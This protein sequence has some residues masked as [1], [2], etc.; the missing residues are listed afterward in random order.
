MK[1]VVYLDNNATTCVAPE[2]LA[3]MLPYFSEWYGNPS[4]MHHFGGQVAKKLEE[5]RERVAALLGAEPTEIVF[6]GCGTESDSTAIRGILESYPEK[7]H[8]VTTRVEHPAVLTLGRYLAKRGYEVTELSVD[9]Q[10]MIDL[11]EL[12]DVVSDHTAIVSLM[13]ANNETGTIFPVEEAA[14][15]AKSVDAVFHTDA[16][17]AAGKI[18]INMA[19]SNMDLLAISGHKLHA[20]KGVGVLYVRRGTR[21][22]PF[23]LGGHQE[24]GRRAG[25][26]NTAS[27]VAL[28]KACGI[29]HDQDRKSVV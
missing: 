8:L 13:W 26:E 28:G 25:T 5:A 4:S 7:R 6:T 10:G 19:Q 18:P 21:L 24:R 16:V 29:A 15:I 23:L 27:I 17:Q 2:V 20:P 9:A 11:D 14:A 1:R 12:R 22:R 3:G